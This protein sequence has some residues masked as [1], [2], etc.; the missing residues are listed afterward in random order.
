MGVLYLHQPRLLCVVG[1]Q[2]LQT[3]GMYSRQGQQSIEELCYCQLGSQHLQI[4]KTCAGFI[5]G[6]SVIRI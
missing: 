2:L 3:C 5:L 6:A 4:H 1:A